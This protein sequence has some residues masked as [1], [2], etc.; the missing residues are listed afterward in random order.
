MGSQKII[1][2]LKS[3]KGKLSYKCSKSI[4]LHIKVKYPFITKN[5]EVAKDLR[6]KFHIPPCSILSGLSKSPIFNDQ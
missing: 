4:C 5:T 1:K 3:G 6:I 2:L